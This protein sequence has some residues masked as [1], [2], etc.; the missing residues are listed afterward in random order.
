MSR[1][2]SLLAAALC[3][4]VHFDFAQTVGA[5]DRPNIV[6]IVADDLGYGDLGVHGGK[7]CPTPRMDSI[8]AG[9]VRCT[10]GYVSGP[11]CSPTRAGL[12][13]GRY[14]TRFGHEFNPGPAS[15]PA[16]R[17][18]GLDL[19]QTTLAD[20]LQTAGY[21]T[22]MV[23]KW[24]LGS[25]PEFHPQRRGFQEFF[26]FLDGARSYYPAK[27]KDLDPVLRGTTPAGETAYLTEALGREAAAFV[28]RHRAAP[29]FL[30]LT[31]NAVHTPLEATDKYLARFPNVADPKRRAYCAMLSAMDDAVGVLLDEL[32]ADGLTENTLIFFISDNGGP[33]SVNGSN[34]GLL[35]GNKT[36]VWEGGIRVPFFVQWPA[37]LPRDKTYDEPVIQ[38]DILP[39]ALAAAGKPIAAGDGLDG[40]DL[41]PFLAGTQTG[42]PHAALFW[43]FGLHRA[44]RIGDWKLT[45]S[46]LDGTGRGSRNDTE[47]PTGL[48]NLREDVGEQHDLAAQHPE[49]LRELQA[50][51]DAW[52]RQNVPASW[53]WI[54]QFNPRGGKV[55]SVDAK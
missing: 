23:G 53:N 15:F 36:T 47:I 32:A 4:Y 20:R 49:K 42:S 12:L 43:R 13:T 7:D 30:Y 54:E 22:G 40:V 55:K 33:T 28:D 5:A 25:T 11:Y 16:N 41:T 37:R 46:P 26:G 52:D 3:C 14:Q 9:G 8:A 35:R 45:R 50:A 31:F 39:T 18:R 44:A 27:G 38:L 48:Y 1:R 34:N 51:W 10:S 24:H 21:A 17:S 6:V 2:T 29:F 19:K